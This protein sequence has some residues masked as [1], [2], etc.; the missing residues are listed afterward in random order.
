MNFDVCKVLCSENVMNNYP[1]MRG[2]SLGLHLLMAHVI[3]PFFFPLVLGQFQ[4]CQH[5]PELEADTPCPGAS[6]VRLSGNK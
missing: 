3:I 6:V 4:S 1:G 5:L 2:M